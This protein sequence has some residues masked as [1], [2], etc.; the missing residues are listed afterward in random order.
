MLS[1]PYTWSLTAIA[2]LTAVALLWVWRRFSNPDRIALAKRQ[3]HARLYAMRLY[4]DDPRLIFRT[5]GQ[6]FSWTLRYLAAMLRPMALAIV[7]MFVLCLQLDNVYGHRL[8]GPGEAAVVTA[9]FA[10]NADV[11]TLAAKLE[12]RGVIVES[13]AVRIPA[14]SQVC[15]RV[16]GI[17]GASGS[18][19]LHVDGTAISKAFACGHNWGWPPRIE[20]A[21]PAASLDVFGY[22]IDWPVWFLLVS[23]LAMLALRKRL[24]VVL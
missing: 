8:P 1:A 22:A 16:R 2:I 21:C 19:V 5:Q 6:L 13:P 10:G 24:G 15:W 17:G 18:L 12:G 3:T 23:L 20:V 11:L 7:P 9:Q 4:A 14:R